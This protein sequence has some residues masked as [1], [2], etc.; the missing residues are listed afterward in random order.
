[1]YVLVNNVRVKFIHKNKTKSVHTQWSL[2]VK[3][4]KKVSF[5]R[6][7]FFFFFLI[8]IKFVTFYYR[9]YR[10]TLYDILNGIF[11]H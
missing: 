5:L 10:Y 8:Y 11:L 9:A 4:H 3:T 2:V 7:S 6:I 1:M